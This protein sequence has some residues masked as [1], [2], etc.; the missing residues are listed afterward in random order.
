[1][2]RKLVDDYA[3]APQI[4]ADLLP[5]IAEAGY[6]TVIDNRPDAEIPPPEAS[7]VMAEAARAAGLAFVYN[8]VSGGM[9]TPENI[10]TQARAIAEAEGP[11][12]A[13][14]RSG[15]RS[16]IVW[17]FAMAG[18]LPTEEIVRRVEAAGYP[19]AQLAPQIDA[20]AAS[21]TEGAE[22]TEG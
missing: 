4:S 20:F 18:R 11:V 16:A 10:A 13:Y 2:F 9:L 19:I 8:P 7:D 17:A 21:R 1:M 3:V 14:C 15:N 22:G 12:L 6:R 5:A